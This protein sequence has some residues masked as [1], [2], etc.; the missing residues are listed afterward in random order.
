M[1]NPEKARLEFDQAI[2]KYL[3]TAQIPLGQ[4]KFEQL[5]NIVSFMRERL[6]TVFQYLLPKFIPMFAPA[7]VALNMLRELT[8]QT[9][10]GDHG[11][12]MLILETTRG[13]PQNVTTEMDLALWETART[14]RFRIVGCI[15]RLRRPVACPPL[16]RGDSAL[17][18]AERGEALHGSI[19]DARRGR[20]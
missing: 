1:H 2:D 19:W 18:R 7:M 4:A 11:F 10:A 15:Q 12:S 3:S 17:D 8:G 14:I 5:A 20:D 6:A 9:D 16:S 13:L